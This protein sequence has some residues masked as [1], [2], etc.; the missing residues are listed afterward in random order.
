MNSGTYTY[1]SKYLHPTWARGL[2]IPMYSLIAT[3]KY[4]SSRI[5]CK[6]NKSQQGIFGFSNMFK[7]NPRAIVFTRGISL[8]KIAYGG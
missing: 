7:I 4:S 8:I 3:I 2:S 6:V 5:N 1:K